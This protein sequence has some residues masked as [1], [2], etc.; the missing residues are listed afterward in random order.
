MKNPTK[1][2]PYIT[3]AVYPEVY[4]YRH[5]QT[6]KA[7]REHVEMFLQWLNSRRELITD[8]RIFGG[9]NPEEYVGKKLS[10]YD[11]MQLTQ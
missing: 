9:T 3:G 1:A 5:E 4:S 8:Q 11:I 2:V 7:L 6:V 10:M